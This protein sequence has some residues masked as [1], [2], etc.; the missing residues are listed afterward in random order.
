M[1]IRL[2]CLKSSC[3]TKFSLYVA[4][5]KTSAKAQIRSFQLIPYIRIKF[6]TR[7][8]TGPPSRG[9]PRQYLSNLRACPE[10][11]GKLRDRRGCKTRA[12][13][14]SGRPNFNQRVICFY[15][16]SIYQ[17]HYN[18]L[19]NWLWLARTRESSPLERHLSHSSP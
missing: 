19:F 2:G 15:L 1:K 18:L 13:L 14:V 17:I 4:V 9:A 11:L 10:V 12:A 7:L 8:P 16:R 3:I 6:S 5:F